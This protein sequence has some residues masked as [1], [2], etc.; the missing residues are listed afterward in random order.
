[1]PGDFLPFDAAPRVQFPAREDLL[2]DIG[3]WLM[4]CA[5]GVL[6]GSDHSRVDPDRPLLSVTDVGVAA[7]LVADPLPR[8]VA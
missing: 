2:G 3:G 8:A 7:R 6:M 1:L 5:G 4:A